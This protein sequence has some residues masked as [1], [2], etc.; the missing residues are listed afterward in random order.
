MMLMMLILMMFAKL[1]VPGLLK[2]RISRNEGHDVITFA[3]DV[4]N[5]I[6]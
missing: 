1:V 3:H 6:L 2:L 5:N 4:I